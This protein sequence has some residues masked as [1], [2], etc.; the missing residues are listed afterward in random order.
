MT[1]WKD[2]LERRNEVKAAFAE[3]ARA[4]AQQMTDEWESILDD[5]E[6]GPPIFDQIKLDVVWSRSD[7][8]KAL[9]KPLAD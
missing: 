7:A 6:A 4:A 2:S 9:E 5:P 1:T 8:R 3:G